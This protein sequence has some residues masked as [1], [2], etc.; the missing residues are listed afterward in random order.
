MDEMHVI[1]LEG[2][3]LLVSM[4]MLKEVETRRLELRYVSVEHIQPN[5]NMM[6]RVAGRI[7]D[8][9]SFDVCMQMLSDAVCDYR[10]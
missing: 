2:D 3:S 6:L 9:T 4:R 7:A 1:V 10:R 5:G 8:A